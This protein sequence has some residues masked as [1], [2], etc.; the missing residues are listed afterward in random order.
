MRGFTLLE[1]LVAVSMTL[2]IMV[3]LYGAYTSNVETIQLASQEGEAFQTARIILDLIHKDL[4]SAFPVNGRGLSGVDMEINGN[5]AD[6]LSI[7]TLRGSISDQRAYH[8]DL[9][10]VDY[11]GEEDPDG[12]GFILYRS[13]YEV[14]CGEEPMG[15]V[16]HELVRGVRALDVVYE[17]QAGIGQEDWTTGGP[18][19]GGNFPAVIRI[20][21]VL[22]AGPDRE[23]A[24]VTGVH[25]AWG[26]YGSP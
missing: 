24:F 15:K 1:I 19:E 11:Y 17:D 10:I 12:N 26:V 22:A 6:R 16:T 4:E 18:G 7:A 9:K 21:L 23:L 25:P 3:G 2:I 13:E 14:A 20:R 8:S 5:P